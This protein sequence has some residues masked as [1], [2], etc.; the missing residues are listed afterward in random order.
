MIHHCYITLR[1][2]HLKDARF[3]WYLFYNLQKRYLWLLYTGTFTSLKLFIYTCI[4]V[5]F[6]FIFFWGGGG[7]F[8]PISL[9]YVPF[10]PPPIFPLLSLLIFGAMQILWH[11]LTDLRSIVQLHVPPSGVPWVFPDDEFEGWVSDVKVGVLQKV[12]VLDLW[13]CD[14]WVLL[15]VFPVKKKT[16]KLAN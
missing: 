16:F 4:Y 5:L 14:Q 10:N 2:Y 7:I 3:S 13:L 12:S 15:C 8:P 6:V 9:F 11:S 1:F